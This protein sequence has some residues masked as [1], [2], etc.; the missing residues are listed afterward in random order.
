MDPRLAAP[1]MA[2]ASLSTGSRAHLLLPSRGTCTSRTSRGDNVFIDVS[3]SPA[4]LRLFV[5]NP[6]QLLQNVLYS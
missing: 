3:A 6:V 2:Q 5:S 1:G 4:S